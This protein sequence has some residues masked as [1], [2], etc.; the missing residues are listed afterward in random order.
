MYKAGGIHIHI[1]LWLDEALIYDIDWLQDAC[2]NAKANILSEVHHDFGDNA[3]TQIILLSESHASIHTWPEAN[4]AAIDFFFCGKADYNAAISTIL[5]KYKVKK[6]SI[7]IHKR[8]EY[9]ES[10]L[11]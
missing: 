3:F 8:G 5:E 4:F 6:S 9:K 1:D 11:G 10:I 7:E 2:R